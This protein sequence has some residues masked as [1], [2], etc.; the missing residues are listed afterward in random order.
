M[1]GGFRE[2]LTDK[3]CGNFKWLMLSGSR[4][5]EFLGGQGVTALGNLKLS[6]RDSLL[7]DVKLTVPAEEV[8]RLCYAALSLSAGLFPTPLLG[9]A[10]T[11]CVRC[12]EDPA[13]PRIPRKSSSASVKTASSSATSADLGG[14]SPIVP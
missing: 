11:R 13:P 2:H 5:L 10:W 3:A 7:L 14:T 6:R 4:A 8:A 9:S 12:P 1:C